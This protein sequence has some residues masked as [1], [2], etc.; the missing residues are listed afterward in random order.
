[1]PTKKEPLDIELAVEEIMGSKKYRDL[2]IHAETVRDL[3]RVEMRHYKSRKEIVKA[4]RKK[5]HRIVA[6]Y[7]G[8]PDYAAAARE[9]DAAFGQG[10][11]AA[12]RAACQRILAAHA[13]TEERQSIL[14]VFYPALFRVTGAPESLIDIACG[15]N[16]LSFPWMGLPGSLR[17]YAYDIHQERVAFINHYFRLQGLAP[18]AKVQDILVHFPEER[19]DL[20]LVLKEVH[21]FERRRR[22]SSLPLLRALRARHLVVTL[23]IR[24]LTGRRD[25][26]ERHRQLFYDLVKDEPWRA[27]EIEFENELAFCVDKGASDG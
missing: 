8:D 10:D 2:N 25:L 12:E 23:P 21:T 4:V 20:A 26:A 13:S 11:P 9:L 14:G 3:V 18:L 16:P 24:N 17:Y 22:G 19:V 5:L 1:M 6:T 7:L 15:L 27:T